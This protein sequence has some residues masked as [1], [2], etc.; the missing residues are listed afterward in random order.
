VI[1]QL[2]RKDSYKRYC[3][4]FQKGSYMYFQIKIGYIYVYHFEN[5]VDSN[6]TM[7]QLQD[8]RHLLIYK[9]LS[10]LQAIQ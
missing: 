10:I 2:S 1:L 9:F 7:A 3:N 6:V 4:D 8:N 5:C